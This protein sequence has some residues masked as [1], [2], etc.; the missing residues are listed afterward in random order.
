MKVATFNANSIRARLP[1]VQKWI[2]EAAPD[3]LCLQE[4]KTPDEF[5]PV[6]EFNKL[7]YT[8][9]YKGQKGYNGVAIASKKPPD[10][11]ICGFGDR[12]DSD[13]SR[14]IYAAFG[15]IHIVNTY[16]PQGREITH[17]MYRYKLKWF[18]RLEK[19][20]STNF[21]TRQKLL[22][23]G[24]LNIAP[25]PLD[26]HNPEKQTNHV[27][28]HEDVRKAFEKTRAWGFTDIFRMFHPEPGQYSFYDYR[29]KDPVKNKTGWRVDHMLATNTLAKRAKDC[30]IDIDPRTWPKPS[31]H[32]FM[33]AEFNL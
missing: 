16:V 17:E 18:A 9:R 32:T 21:T 6:T 3:I 23:T 33:I 15:P 5:F 31:D 29:T 2:R 28:F 1:I 11:F 22:W 12:P 30:Y 13:E 8:V 24:D 7:G 4:T 26:V 20:F 10:K 19:Y 27:C 14:L 25:T